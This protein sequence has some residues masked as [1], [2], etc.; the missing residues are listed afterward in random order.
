MYEIQQDLSIIF[1]YVRVL[2]IYRERLS[3]AFEYGTYRDKDRSSAG[4][5]PK[6]PSRH[7]RAP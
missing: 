2:N 5:R 3:V 7:P 1:V 4:I 6:R